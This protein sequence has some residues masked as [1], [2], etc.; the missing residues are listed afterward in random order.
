MLPITA[1]SILHSFDYDDDGLLSENEV[2]GDTAFA[3]LVGIDAAFTQ[4]SELT[5]GAGGTV[6][7]ENPHEVPF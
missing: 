7:E 5:S 3:E 6:G 4:V 2:L 1:S